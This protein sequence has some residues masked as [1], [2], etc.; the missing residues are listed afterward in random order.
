[1]IPRESHASHCV[2]TKT[3]EPDKQ[4]P[5]HTM[6]SADAR[7]LLLRANGVWFTSVDSLICHK[8]KV[9]ADVVRVLAVCPQ[10][11]RDE[12]VP[13]GLPAAENLRPQRGWFSTL[14][15]GRLLG[16]ISSPAQAAVKTRFREREATC[17]R[18]GRQGR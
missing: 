17:Q 4:T 11:V 7:P 2:P 10:T 15:S 8:S 9:T 1:M 18:D 16:S 13:V 14:P 6:C 3:A 12:L 5:A